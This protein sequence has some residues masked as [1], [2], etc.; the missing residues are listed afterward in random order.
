[1]KKTLIA[2]AVV[3][4][5]FARG[6][7]CDANVN[8]AL[9]QYK[10]SHVS[11]AEIAAISHMIQEEKLA[12]DVYIT[13]YNKWKL[14][15]FANIAKAEQHHMD[16]V[17][18][19]LQRY[20]LPN[21]IATLEGKIGVFPSAKFQ[22]LYHKLVN[23]GSRSRVDALKVGALIEDLDIYDLEKFMQKTHSKDILFIFKNLT[24]GSRN[25][26][27]AFMRWLRKYNANYTPQYISTQQFKRIIHSNFERRLIK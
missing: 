7:N 1:M 10:V 2:L 8:F 11:K 6:A 25:H 19:L 23:M 12:R 18:M 22:R 4:S 15:V 5:L 26:L 27:R 24:R 21:D 14:R 16:M 9:N 3:S 17:K 20:N 13:L